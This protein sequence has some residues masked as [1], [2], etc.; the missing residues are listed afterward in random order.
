MVTALVFWFH[1]LATAESEPAS[2][3]LSRAP[4]SGS[5][6][7]DDQTKVVVASLTDTSPNSPSSKAPQQ[8]AQEAMES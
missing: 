6:L 5:A 1:R 2:D 7:L 3:G 8:R 4:S